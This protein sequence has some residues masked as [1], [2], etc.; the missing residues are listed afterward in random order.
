VTPLTKPGPTTADGDEA[1]PRPGLIEVP[2]PKDVRVLVVDDQEPVRTVLGRI[3][4]GVGYLVAEADSVSAAR[5][6][7]SR[8][9]VEVILLDLTMPKESGLVL[10]EE[11]APAAPDTTVIVVS[12]TDDVESAVQAMKDGAYDYLTKPFSSDT[13]LLA[14]RRAL[15][16]RRLEIENRDYRLHLEDLVRDR[17]R[18]LREV[19]RRLADTQAAIVWV[20]CSLAESRDANTGAHL[21]RMATYCRSLALSLPEKV[22]REHGVDEQYADHL[23]QSAPLHDIGKVAIPDS[24]LLKPGPL[25]PCEYEVIKRHPVVGREILEAVRGRLSPESAPALDL[26]IDICIGHHERFDGTGYPAGLK[27]AEIPLGARIAALADVYDA[28]TSSRPYRPIAFTHEQARALIVSECGRAFDPAAV[29]AFLLVES[30][31]RDV[32][33]RLRDDPAIWAE[34][35]FT[36]ARDLESLALGSTRR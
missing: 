1:R 31:I 5:R 20:A 12:G 8:S 7:L 28:T 4:K 6:E 2:E 23:F 24:I 16:R 21:D 26:G 22:K 34:H 35:P 36:R 32:A 27:R 15:E 19:A 9:S 30:E 18:R 33:E 25:S 17:T 13:V 14:L 29:D 10:L 3:L 11:V